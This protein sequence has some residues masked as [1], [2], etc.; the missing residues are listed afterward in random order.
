MSKKNGIKQIKINESRQK[1]VKKLIAET[2]LAAKKLREVKKIKNATLAARKLEKAKQTR[3][4]M[5]AAIR[6][7]RKRRIKKPALDAKNSEEKGKT[8]KLTTIVVLLLFWSD[9]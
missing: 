6:Q 3:E 5:Q 7:K 8:E 9:Y 2:A 4:A 1:V